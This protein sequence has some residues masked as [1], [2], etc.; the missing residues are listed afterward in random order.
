VRGCIALLH[1]RRDS[2]NNSALLSGQKG[3]PSKLWNFNLN[4]LPPEIAPTPRQYPPS[5]GISALSLEIIF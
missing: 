1:I 3:S 2:A 5:T 4:Y